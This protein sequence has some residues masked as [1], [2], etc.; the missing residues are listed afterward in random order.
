VRERAVSETTAPLVRHEPEAQRFVA[1]VDGEPALL[2]Y[3]RAGDGSVAFSHTEVPARA[4]GRG[5]AAELVRQALAWARAE[6]LRV[7]PLCSYVAAYMR[8]HPDTHDLLM[9][10]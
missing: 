4:Q 6:G 8:R 10:R 2:L 7:R 1:D 3:R 5:I 9:P